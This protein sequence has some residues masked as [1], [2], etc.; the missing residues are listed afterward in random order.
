MTA[1]HLK[2]E[3]YRGVRNPLIR[4]IC[5]KLL[6]SKPGGNPRPYAVYVDESDI[7]WVSDFGANALVR[8]DPESEEF[9]AFP[10][11]ATPGEVRQILGRAGEVWAPQSAAD[12]IVV[13]R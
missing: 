5:G 9:N 6:R 13:I 3:N 12:S 8:F 1:L 10:L 2:S 4:G 11:P 7:V